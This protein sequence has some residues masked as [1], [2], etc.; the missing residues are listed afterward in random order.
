MAELRRRLAR[1][2]AEAGALEMAEEQTH[3]V[4]LVIGKQ[5]LFE[6]RAASDQVG[7]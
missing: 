3:S 5:S 6:A 2:E 4:Q 1:L 7:S